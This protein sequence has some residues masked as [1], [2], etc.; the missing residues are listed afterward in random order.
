M[1]AQ[2]PPLGMTAALMACYL[3]A[4]SAAQGATA[5]PASNPLC[6]DAPQT[7]G[8]SPEDLAKARVAHA[9]NEA[10][11]ERRYKE[12]QALTVPATKTDLTLLCDGYAVNVWFSASL[13]TW[14]MGENR[15]VWRVDSVSSVQISFARVSG[16]GTGKFFDATGSIDRV[17]GWFSRDQGIYPYPPRG[18]CAPAV[19]KF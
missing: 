4:A 9:A 1:R 13:L 15:E 3:A 12:Q 8:C 5:P 2:F 11:L 17:S 6:S 14:G 10:D 18:Q 16:T 19:P 7:P